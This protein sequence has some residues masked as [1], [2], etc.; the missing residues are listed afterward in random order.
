MLTTTSDPYQSRPA[1]PAAADATPKPWRNNT[2]ALSRTP[3]PLN[4]IGSTC[5][6]ETA[7][8]KATAPPIGTDRSSAWKMNRYD[9]TT[10]NWYT[11]AVASTRNI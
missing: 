1:V 6:I 4:E 11:S 2:S 3:S 10:D 9:S 8:M 7:G 5:S